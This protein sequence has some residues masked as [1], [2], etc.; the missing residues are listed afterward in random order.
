MLNF[1]YTID[2]S[3]CVIIE[4]LRIRRNLI[5]GY[6]SISV[7]RWIERVNREY[8]LKLENERIR[9]E[10]ILEGKQKDIDMLKGKKSRE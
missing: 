9:Y 3:W 1:I 7:L 8:Q 10:A 4:K 5:G 2:W 6:D